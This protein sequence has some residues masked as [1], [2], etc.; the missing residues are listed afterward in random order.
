MKN[1]LLFI[2]VIL[3]TVCYG[4]S[5]EP[6]VVT[7]Q[8]ISIPGVLVV[9]AWKNEHKNQEYQGN[10]KFFYGFAEGDEISIDFS[11]EN[12]KGTNQIEISEYESKSVVFSNKEFQSLEGIKI[13]VPKTAVYKFEFAT[14]HM[15]DRNC[16]VI[17]KRTPSSDATKNFKTNVYWRTTNDTIFTT[18]QERYLVKTDTIASNLTNRVEKVHSVGNMNGNKSSFN[19]EIPENTIAW[20][21]Y[22]G[23]DQSGQQAYEDAS[24]A[25]ASS[26]SSLT[27]KI[28]GYGPLAALALGSASYITQLQH[29]EDIDYYIMDNTNARLFESNQLCTYIRKGKV[30]NDFSRITSPLAGNYFVCLSN[31]NAIT[32]VN[33]T[34]KITAIQVNQVWDAKSVQKINITSRQEAYLKN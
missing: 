8:N 20:S 33:V 29:G 7:T 24:K 18:E 11:M 32:G 17:V 13:K 16:K 21:Y 30:I 1:I 12:K 4:E 34:V 27:S 15:F 9:T 5:L 26:V 28:P 22:I 19:F 2:G 6:I 23:V 3:S 10:P 25:L 14:N 31:D